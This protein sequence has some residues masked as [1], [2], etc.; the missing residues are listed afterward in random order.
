MKNAVGLNQTPRL[1]TNHRVLLRLLSSQE[2][3]SRRDLAKQMQITPAALTHLSADLLRWKLVKEHGILNEPHRVG[4]KKIRLTINAQYKS[5]IA[6][7]LSPN[8][9]QIAITNLLGRVTAQREIALIADQ[10]SVGEYIQQLSQAI[11]ALTQQQRLTPNKILGVGVSIPQPIDEHGV[12][13]PHLHG[14]W[15]VPVAIKELLA[16]ALPYDIYVDY[17]LYAFMKAHLIFLPLQQYQDI[18]FIEWSDHLEASLVIGGKIYQPAYRDRLSLAHYLVEPDGRPCHCG[19]RGCLEQYISTAQ[20]LQAMQA[21]AIDGHSMTHV[22]L[23]SL[24]EQADQEPQAIASEYLA[25][26]QDAVRKMAHV[27]LN[28]TSIFQPQYIIC[29]GFLFEQ[30]WIYRQVVETLVS[31][32]PNYPIQLFQ[33]SSLR[34]QRSIISGVSSVTSATI[35]LTS[36]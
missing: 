25:I 22:E 20:L 17:D 31:E 15:S 28:V 5:I 24:L 34:Y 3:L 16:N 18:L 32:D 7:S 4:R 33:R 1:S 35:F 8:R 6:L 10:Q 12:T 9:V 14:I 30:N 27:V 19:R 2:N 11:L 26:W 36:K 29:L 21:T 23:A 13:I